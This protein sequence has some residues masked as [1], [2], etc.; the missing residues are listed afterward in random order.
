MNNQKVVVQESKVATPGVYD[1]IMIVI[2][3]KQLPARPIE[4]IFGDDK[5]PIKATK[6]E[7]TDPGTGQLLQFSSDEVKWSPDGTA[8]FGEQPPKAVKPDVIVIVTPK[9]RIR[10]SALPNIGQVKTEVQINEIAIC[11]FKDPIEEG[12]FTFE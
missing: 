11:P 1:K 9:P 5:L 4:F 6:W 2:K 10:V 3:G 8:Y 7:T 12:I